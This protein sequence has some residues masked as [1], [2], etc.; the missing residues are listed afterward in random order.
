[1]KSLFFHA[2]AGHPKVAPALMGQAGNTLRPFNQYLRQAVRTAQERQTRYALPWEAVPQQYTL[3]LQAL[4]RWLAIPREPP[5]VVLTDWP[6]DAEPPVGVPLMVV[7]RSL[8]INVVEHRRAKGGLQVF[9][10]G[11]LQA[12][13]S[14]FWGGRLCTFEIRG[15]AGPPRLIEFEPGRALEIRAVVQDDDHWRISVEWPGN[16]PEAFDWRIDGAER[17]VEVFPPLQ[18]LASLTDDEG[19]AWKAADGSL[20]VDQRPEQ[21][22]LHG[23]DGLRYRWYEPKSKRG[24]GLWLQLLPSDDEGGD[25]YLDPRAA[26]CEDQVSEV[27]TAAKHWEGEKIKVLRVDRERYQLLVERLP[28]SEARL[29]LPLD[30]RNLGLQRRALY[31]LSTAPLPHHQGL[32]RLC[33]D[34][35]RCRWPLVRPA[36]VDEWFVLSDETRNGTD[37]QRAFVRKALGSVEGGLGPDK[38]DITLL[39]GPPGSGKT[40]AICEL[41]LQCATRG[42]RVLLC[43]STHAAIDNVLERLG[44][45]DV[46][47]VRIGRAE[48]IDSSVRHQ[49]IDERIEALVSQWRGLDAFAGQG[50]GT[51][52]EMAERTII[53]GADLTCGTTMGIVNHPLF[54]GQS[55]DLKVWQRPICVRAEWDVLIVDEA[56]KTTIQ[57]FLVPGLMARR[58]VIVG[59]VRQLPPF[60]DRAEIVANLR[61]L[62]DEKDQPV[63]PPEHQRARFLLWWLARPVV[64]QPQ[65]RFLIAEPAAVLDWLERELAHEDRPL[66]AVRILADGVRL[67]FRSPAHRVPVSSLRRG[68]PDAVHLAAAEWV[69]VDTELLPLVERW[70]P[71]TLLT[72][73]E[74]LREASVD[75]VIPSSAAWRFRRQRWLDRGVKLRKPIRVRGRRR[76]QADRLDE[77]EVHEADTLQ[78]KDWASEV[79]WRLTRTHELKRSRRQDMRARYRE[80]IDRLSPN[81]ADVSEAIDEIR[82]IGLPSILEVVQEGIGEEH[83]KR[84]SAL[85]LGLQRR[86]PRVF[87]QRFE[88]LGWQHRMHPEISAFPRAHVYA[89]EALQDAN[90][91]AARDDAIGWDFGAGEFPSRRVWLDVRGQES[92]GANAAEVEAIER[93]VRAFLAWAKR[94]PDIGDRRAWEVACLAFYVKQEAALRAMLQRVTGDDRK[95]RFSPKGSDVEIVCG[96]VDRFQGREADLVFLSLRNTGRVGFLDSVNR[97]NVAVT[98][99]RQ[100]LVI[101]G[102]HSYFVEC[103]VAELEELAKDCRRVDGR[104][105]FGGRRGQ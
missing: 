34:P 103:G 7:T 13:D 33:E 30:T 84:A 82:S 58:W 21:R 55:R 96:T 27:W 1:M 76:K 36:D 97:L 51:L 41:I 45:W 93:G 70:L 3:R 53:M 42:L 59:D 18:G 39:E 62:V 23:N 71:A 2:V 67:P 31:Q 73:D 29:H 54:R 20:K 80:Q 8:Q 48:R 25:E 65:V 43:G 79:T 47:A 12:D 63:F 91:I 5:A 94:R 44:E 81:A 74:G 16:Q 35:D 78:K 52:R 104:R 4:D 86:S 32:L 11:D 98:R 105:T 95:T 83:S 56:S 89:G 37:D 64:R 57:E 50:D 19:G 99:A 49:Q 68:T 77:L 101:V 92:S 14:I 10:D 22:V 28:P 15:E 69:L 87:E 60:A 38:G 66:H 6:E 85:T 102:K 46:E 26:F 100:Q 40:T 17:R 9:L 61:G 88:S 90:T 24:G 72:Y 75:G